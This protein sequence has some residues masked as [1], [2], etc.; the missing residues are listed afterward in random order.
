MPEYSPGKVLL[1]LLIEDLCNHRPPKCLTFFEG[2]APYKDVFGT[3]V[4]EDASVLL[5]HGK[6]RLA[7]RLPHRCAFR[8]ADPHCHC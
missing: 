5:V 8:V 3:G 1:Y 4:L 6:G 7:A 2:G